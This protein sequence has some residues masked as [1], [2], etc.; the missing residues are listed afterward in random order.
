[1]SAP[2]VAVAEEE[3]RLLGASA[4]GP[5]HLLLALCRDEGAA[6]SALAAAG[7]RPAD[8]AAGLPR[9]EPWVGHV[10]GVTHP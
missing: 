8:V 10:F 1:M 6:G 4:V 3:A 9:A 5:E 7:V 2:V